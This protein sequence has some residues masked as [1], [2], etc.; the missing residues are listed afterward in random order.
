[1]EYVIL[2]IERITNSKG[3]LLISSILLIVNYLFLCDSKPPNS[4]YL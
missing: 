1:M 4:M 3:N 2:D